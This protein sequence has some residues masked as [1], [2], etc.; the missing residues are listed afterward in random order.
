[1]YLEA[2]AVMRDSGVVT[3]KVTGVYNGD[4]SPY[5]DRGTEPGIYILQPDEKNPVLCTFQYMLSLTF[6]L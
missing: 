5:W 4:D 2:T 1:M 6:H 3:G